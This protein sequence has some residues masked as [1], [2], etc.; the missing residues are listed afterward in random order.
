M[1][2]TLPEAIWLRRR[3]ASATTSCIGYPTAH[4]AGLAELAAAEQ[5]AAA[6][7]LMVDSVDQ[8]DLIDA[9]VAPARRPDAAR[10]PRPRRLLAAAGRAYAR[11]R[12]P[13]AAA[14]ARPRSASWPRRSPPGP[15]SAWSG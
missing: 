11:R 10:L 3:P 12:A 6:I 15:A 9:V 2:Y 13:V 7:T 4:R 1:A 8:L 5:L 14:L